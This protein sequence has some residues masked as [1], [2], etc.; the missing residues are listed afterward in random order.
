MKNAKLILATGMG[1]P[2]ST[3]EQIPLI[4]R[5]GFDGVFT[6]WSDGAPISEWAKI[7]SD[8]GMIYQ[9]LHA[10][11]TRANRMW[12]DGS[13]GEDVADELCRCLNACAENGIPITVAHAF[14]GFDTHNPNPW[15]IKRFGRV[16]DYAKNIGVKLAL[17][18]TEGE[19]YLELLMDALSDNPAVGFCID[20]GH[21]MCYNR[22]RDLITRWG[23]RL[24]ATHLNDNMGITDENN[25]TWLDD[26][27]LL[28]FDGIADWQGIAD[29]LCAVG[30]RGA[31]TFELTSKSKPGRNT[32]DRYA[33][34]SFEEYLAQA[35]QRAV[36]FREMF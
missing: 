15:G 22:S 6:G 35:Y 28:P 1:Y 4:G 12:E 10:P 30:Y 14:I 24:I 32:H 21:E 20:T 18:N 33:A 19:E 9:S 7:V 31:L 17:E 29:R 23:D 36:R 3:E 13:E 8:N 26:A 25:I 27:H 11:F 16:A 2:V 34:W 5:A